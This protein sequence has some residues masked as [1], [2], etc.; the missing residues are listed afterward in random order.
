MAT[1]QTTGELWAVA[2]AGFT[3]RM[4][5][6][7][8]AGKLFSSA[9]A[10][11]VDLVRTGVPWGRSIHHWFRHE[12]KNQHP[13]GHVLDDVAT[14]DSLRRHCNRSHRQRLHPITG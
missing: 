14:F 2:D 8:F 7:H 11:L 6:Y 4:V 10:G 9:G 13:Q 1:Q 5:L 12:R 3:P